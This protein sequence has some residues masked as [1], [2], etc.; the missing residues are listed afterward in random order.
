[1]RSEVVFELVG[2]GC[3]ESKPDA[4]RVPDAHRM[5]TAVFA[6][7]ASAGVLSDAALASKPAALCVKRD[8]THVPVARSVAPSSASSLRFTV[9]PPT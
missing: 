9:V 4:T 2:H 7:S 1:M 6:F 8:A 3:V 5:N